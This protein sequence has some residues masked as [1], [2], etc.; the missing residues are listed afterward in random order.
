M[1]ELHVMH[2]LR[3]K[4][5]ELAGTMIL[6]EQQ[7]LRQRVA[8]TH[9]DATMWLF[10]PSIQPSEIDPKQRR[11]TVPGSVTVSVFG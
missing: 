9:L 8:L 10:D 1:A 5:A 11:R 2:A 3:N 7:L 6:L 4:R